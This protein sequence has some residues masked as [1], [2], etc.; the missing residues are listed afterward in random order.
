MCLQVQIYVCNVY[1]AH[2]CCDK[3]LQTYQI[4]TKIIYYFTVSMGQ[5]WVQPGS[6]YSSPLGP[7]KLKSGCWQAVLIS[8]HSG[9]DYTCKFLWIGG[10][11]QFLMVVELRSPFLA[12]YQLGV[13]FSSL[14]PHSSP[15]TWAP[16]SQSQQQH[17]ESFLHLGIF[18]M[19]FSAASLWFFCL[20]LLILWAY[21]IIF[22]LL[23]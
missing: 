8:G 20:L 5:F 18:L 16:T 7:R 19:S 14:K 10:R 9:E 13:A 12:V 6:S 2:C 23:K 3:L 15:C 4:K 17:Q 1:I 22:S 21:V 11:I